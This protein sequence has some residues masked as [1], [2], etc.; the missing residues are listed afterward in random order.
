[1]YGTENNVIVVE[2]RD[3]KKDDDIPTENPKKY[4]CSKNTM[5]ICIIVIVLTLGAIGGIL[6]FIQL[7]NQG[8]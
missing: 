3:A 5:I 2:K 8:S 7:N 1:M 4:S 6:T